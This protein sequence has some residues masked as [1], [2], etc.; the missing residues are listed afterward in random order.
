MALIQ[1]P[2]THT[3]VVYLQLT[4][5]QI[6]LHTRV[7][8]TFDDALEATSASKEWAKI[9]P[10]LFRVRS[11]FDVEKAVLLIVSS[12]NFDLALK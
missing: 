8:L 10:S 1:K 11:G 6:G 2:S 9:F 3:N 5:K 4:K 12:Y 7:P